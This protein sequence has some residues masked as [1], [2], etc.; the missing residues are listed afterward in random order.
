MQR[1]VKTL[2]SAAVAVVLSCGLASAQNHRLV[3]TYIDHG[4]NAAGEAIPGGSIRT[5]VGPTVTVVC[6]DTAVSCTIQANHF[7]QVGHG[8]ATGNLYTVG[9]YLDGVANGDEQILGSTPSDGTYL[10]GAT[11]EFQTK[12]AVGTH[13]V[14]TYVYSL[15]PT[16][17]FNYTT[18]FQVYVP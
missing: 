5:A 14:Q 7:I 12:V 17:V 2:L 1:I 3:E 13:T 15:D 10:M 16:Y 4:Y 18:N 11:S 9:F 8:K 6:P